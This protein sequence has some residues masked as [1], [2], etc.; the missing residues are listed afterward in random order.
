[1]IKV[2]LYA[3]VGVDEDGE[4]RL[5]RFMTYCRRYAEAEGF[6]VVGEFRDCGSGMDRDRPGLNAL[7]RMVAE[8]PM[9]AVVVYNPSQLARSKWHLAS[10]SREFAQHGVKLY[11]VLTPVN[12]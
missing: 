8:Q 12:G 7:R 9:N 10:L 3:R 11:F 6:E 1:M 4:L 5:L 2:V